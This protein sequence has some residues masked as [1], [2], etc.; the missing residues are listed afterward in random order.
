MQSHVDRDAE[1]VLP[2][3][4]WSRLKGRADRAMRGDM[5]GIAGGLPDES[6]LAEWRYKT[7]SIV[8]RP[9][10]EQKIVRISV[11]GG[12]PGADISYCVFRGDRTQCAHLLETAAAALRAGPLGDP[13]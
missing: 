13:E 11:G 9:E 8:E 6:V 7:L 5:S 3:H 1:S 4:F 10:D 12:V 2:P